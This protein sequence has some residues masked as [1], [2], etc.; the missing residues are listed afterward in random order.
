MKTVIIL[1][2]DIIVVIMTLIAIISML[3]ISIGVF[4]NVWWVVICGIY[5]FINLLLTII[6]Y[7]E[8]KLF[9]TNISFLYIGQLMTRLN[10]LKIFKSTKPFG[11]MILILFGIV[12]FI[13]CI[14]YFIKYYNIKSYFDYIRVFKIYER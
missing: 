6:I 2:L 12:I 11:G 3:N 13:S 14:W 10:T 4:L 1:L 7:F 5:F 9:N 8:L